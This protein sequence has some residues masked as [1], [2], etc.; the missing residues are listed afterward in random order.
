MFSLIVKGSL[1]DAAR[2]CELRGIGVEHVHAELPTEVVLIVR[3]DAASIGAWF[4]EDL[5]TSAP[6]E[7][8]A[9]LHYRAA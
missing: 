8:G 7:R 9:L 3:G 5:N 2:E 4:A 1:D 6:Y